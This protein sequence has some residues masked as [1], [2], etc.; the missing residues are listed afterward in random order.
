[1]ADPHGQ[2]L[3]DRGVCTSTFYGFGSSEWVGASVHRK[4]LDR[5]AELEGAMRDAF[6]AQGWE[7]FDDA[8]EAARQVLE[9]GEE[10][11]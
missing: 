1:M 2:E 5:I 10:A 3:R 6:A 7:D 11:K 8:L 9:K 4:A